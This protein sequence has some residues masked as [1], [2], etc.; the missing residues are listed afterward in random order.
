MALPLLDVLIV[1][2][3]PAGLSAALLLARCRRRVLLVDAGRPRHAPARALHGFLTR[4]GV[5]PAAL[6]RAAHAELRRY[7]VERRRASAIH[8]RRDRAFEVTL[9]SGEILAA[10]K[11]LL[12]G[13][14]RDILPDIPGLRGL[15]GRRVHH[16][17]Y[18][19]A[20]EYRDRCLVACG[21]GAAG[22]ALAE[23][24]T[25]WTGEVLLCGPGLDSGLR[26]RAAASGIRVLRGALTRV[27]R[28]G[29]G[30]RLRI[31]DADVRC[32]ALFVSSPHSQ[33]MEFS[34]DLGCALD[35][36]G[37]LR[38]DRR[39]Q[40]T[41]AGVFAAGDLTAGPE[42]AIVAAAK[43]TLAAWAINEDFLLEERRLRA[44]GVRPR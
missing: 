42:F 28:E 1:G 15:Y 6:R 12:A 19:D 22:V 17:P 25:G 14:V 23:R 11:L 32:A 33:G 7:G 40:T 34:R 4:D 24:L 41:V 2:G 31:G 3:G 8:A 44:S 35:G 13:G 18:C 27:A 5:S 9:D 43:G 39:L 21:R 10:R 30:V 36:Q 37:C 16:C 20:F 38:T 29:D 26:S